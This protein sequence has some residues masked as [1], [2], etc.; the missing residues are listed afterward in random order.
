MTEKPEIDA[1][2]GPTP[3]DLEITDITV[4]D[5]DEAVNGK[6]VAV[7]YVGVT[8]ST[9]EEFERLP[10][11]TTAAGGRLTVGD[12]ATVRDAFAELQGGHVR[13]K[14]VLQVR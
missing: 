14:L 2:E 7:H 9:G 4:G 5:G 3:T 6:Q 1:P 10:L 8:H 11:I 12:V 13:G